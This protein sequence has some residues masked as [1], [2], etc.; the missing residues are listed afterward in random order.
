[1]AKIRAAKD[2]AGDELIVIARTD[3]F[4]PAEAMER[5]IAYR[6]A[7]ADMIQ[8]VS[9]TFSSI[10]DLVRLH[11]ECGPLSLQLLGWLERLT[12]AEVESVAAIATYPL[13]ALATTTAALTANFTSLMATKDCSKL[14]R[15]RTS[16]AD[17][18]KFIGF[19]LT[20][21][22]QRRFYSPRS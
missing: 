20:L 9:K 4:N 5:A 3:A 15:E 19:S 13:V 10:D 7:G 12:K 8:P 1:M 16:L 22:S 21:E 11:K 17:F 18:D 14:P 6:E 2:A